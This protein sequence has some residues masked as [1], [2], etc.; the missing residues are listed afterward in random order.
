MTG[1]TKLIL[2]LFFCG[3]CNISF[4]VLIALYQRQISAVKN[5]FCPGLAK[6]VLIFMISIFVKNFLQFY[7]IH[8][9]NNMFTLESNIYSVVGVALIILRGS[10]ISA[11]Q[12]I[13][14]HLDLRNSHCI[15]LKF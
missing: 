1:L 8:V 2:I 7:S 11:H 10:K 15:S 5:Q 4:L 14:V 6:E 12:I 13:F 9:I 3:K